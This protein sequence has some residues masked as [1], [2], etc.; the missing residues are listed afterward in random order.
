M[1]NWLE[2]TIG[3]FL[4]G[5]VLYGHWKGLIRLALSMLALIVTLVIVRFAMRQN[6]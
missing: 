2:I 3:V 4:L 1:D 5:M 6:L